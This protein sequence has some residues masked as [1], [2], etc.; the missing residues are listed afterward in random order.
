MS[1]EV[2]LLT[3]L[4][5]FSADMVALRLK[6]INTTYLRIN[7]E[8]LADYR[9]TINPVEPSLSVARNGKLIGT[10]KS[11]KAIWF[12]SLPGCL[13]IACALMA[14]QKSISIQRID[15]YLMILKEC[16]ILN[17]Y[18]R[19]YRGWESAIRKYR[20]LLNANICKSC[21]GIRKCGTLKIEDQQ[22]LIS[23]SFLLRPIIDLYHVVMYM[24]FFGAFGL[25]ILAL[26]VELLNFQWG[27][28]VFML[29]AAC[30]TAIILLT[31]AAL[32]Y[33]FYHLR[34]GRFS[35]EYFK[36]CWIDLLNKCRWQV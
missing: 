32:I 11:L 16:R 30:V 27:I 31:V 7:R 34:K 19:E 8:G 36:C 35:V 25:S 14:V 15:T 13:A 26:V 4:Y 12:P 17:Q 2:L 20:H 5:D 22:T 9:L 29:I 6:E 3:S 1:F 28:P 24:S 18:P 10:T 33:V 23:K 21:E